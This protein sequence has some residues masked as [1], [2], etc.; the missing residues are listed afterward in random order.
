MKFT[1]KNTTSLW[2]RYDTHD[3]KIKRK[4]VGYI[5]ETDKGKFGIRF[6][7][8]DLADRCNFR[9]VTLQKKCKTVQEAK[10]FLNQHIDKIVETYKLW[11][12]DD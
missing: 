2:D 9:W 8:E 1:F 4:K 5:Y 11:F 12:F 7:I 3:I 6:S 10:D